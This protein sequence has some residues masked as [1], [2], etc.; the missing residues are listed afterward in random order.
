MNHLESSFNE[1]SFLHSTSCQQL[2]NMRFNTLFCYLILKFVA[3]FRRINSR[4]FVVYVK[5]F[6]GIIKIR[7]I[8]LPKASK[9]NFEC[10]EDI[11]P[12]LL[13]FSLFLSFSVQYV[14]SFRNDFFVHFINPN[15]NILFIKPQCYPNFLEFLKWPV[16]FGKISDTFIDFT[17]YLNQ[18]S[19]MEYG[20]FLRRIPNKVIWTKFWQ[21]TLLL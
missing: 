3:N 17:F 11:W 12:K 15:S 20:S 13:S 14:F 2:F 8:T 6:Y 4:L 10:F 9:S 19:L 16:G 21:K 7:N 1:H 18:I 5:Q